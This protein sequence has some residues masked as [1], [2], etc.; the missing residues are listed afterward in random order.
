M[1]DMIHLSKTIE[2]YDTEGTQCKLCTSVNT[3][4]SILVH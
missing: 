2:L 3:G 4:T 1:H